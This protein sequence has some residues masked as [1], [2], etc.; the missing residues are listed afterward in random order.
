MGDASIVGDLAVFCLPYGLCIRGMLLR[1]A[2]A[3]ISILPTS[4]AGRSGSVREEYLFQLSETNLR[5]FS[6]RS[7]M[8]RSSGAE[9]NAATSG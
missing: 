5:T 2:S 1:H 4:P 6:L 7:A 8:L 3:L 9:S